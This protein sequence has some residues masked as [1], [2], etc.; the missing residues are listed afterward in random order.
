MLIIQIL[1]VSAR[2]PIP[3][4]SV[5]TLASNRRAL[6]FFIDA[7][8]RQEETPRVLPELTHITLQGNGEHK[9]YRPDL[10]PESLRAALE[11]WSLARLS[12]EYF[13]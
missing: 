1:F 6:C 5:P 13:I 12:V 9:S 7:I 3:G 10:E 4:S 8:D 2:S 11:G